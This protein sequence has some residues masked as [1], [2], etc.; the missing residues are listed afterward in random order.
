[1][2]L[3]DQRK[4]LVLNLAVASVVAS[5]G[6]HALGTAVPVDPLSFEAQHPNNSGEVFY[7]SR[8]QVTASGL[9]NGFQSGFGNP[10]SNPGTS[11]NAG[12]GSIYYYKL[13]A[14][15]AGETVA[16]ASMWF[17]S[18]RDS[19]ATAV[20]PPWNVD[21]Y[22]LGFETS[23][24]PHA[25]PL[26]APSGNVHS[27]YVK[28]LYYVGPVQVGATGLNGAP[29]VKIQDDLLTG[30]QWVP[31]SAGANAPRQISADA[32][33]ALG[34]YIRQHVY[35]SL[36]FTPDDDF[37]ALRMNPDVNSYS[38]GNQ[39]Y[40]ISTAQTST[41][42]YPGLITPVLNLVIASQWNRDDSSSTWSSATSWQ[43]AVPNANDR[44]ANFGLAITAPQTVIVDGP[45][46]V[47]M[48]TFNN[49]NSYTVDGSPITL[50]NVPTPVAALASNAAVVVFAGSHAIVA[51]L[52]LESNT[53]F[54]VDSM[55]FVSNLTATG[56]AVR[57]SG[58]GVVVV[59]SGFQSE[60]LNVAAGTLQ[61]TSDDSA[62]RIVRPKALTIGA[63]ARLDL[64]DNKLLTE[65]PVGS[66]NGTSYSGVQGEVQRAYNFGAWDHP[67]LTTSE[68]NAGQNA[69]VLSNTTTI[70]TATA[71]QVLF[72]EPTQTALFQGQTVTG[73]TTIAM[74]TY[75][76]D[77]NMDGL[78]DGADYGVI[79]NFVQFP[80]TDGYVNG[81]FNYDGVIDGADYGVIDNTV[82][83]QGDPFPGV[84]FGASETSG[85]LSDIAAVPEPS[86]C[87]FAALG[88]AALV[89]RRR[90]H[91]A[92]G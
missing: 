51:P 24:E 83:L 48:M 19:S 21:F 65:T 69:G 79:D 26:D 92:R 88:A 91:H 62:N 18:V 84:V 20:Q 67:G 70:A 29:I 7:A 36:A 4:W 61:V 16:S 33:L 73:A 90:R 2:S 75:A 11:P 42:T 64:T 23:A 25:A 89:A 71:A 52:V 74:Y 40:Q 5:A 76:G 81:D 68:E 34:S 44:A 60:S 80:G 38:G 85:S 63:N 45:Q 82:Q 58:G 1:M 87:G 57:K 86:A 30:A 50:A 6:Q 59:G 78:V 54:A 56:R 37:L 15:G 17:S 39:R 14:L 3:R 9:R 47:A 77:L 46:T 10:T 31:N 35:R 43:G 28:S 55:L 12:I 66:F 27:D 41:T 72:I 13:P 22:A 8:A 49:D 53:T 32:E